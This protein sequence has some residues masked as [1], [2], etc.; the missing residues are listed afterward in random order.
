MLIENFLLGDQ[1]VI[2]IVSGALIVRDY[3]VI[4]RCSHE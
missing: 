3:Q 1:L 4:R 2:I